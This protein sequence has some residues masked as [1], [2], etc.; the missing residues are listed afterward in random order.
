MGDK[1]TDLL[2]AVFTHAG[3]VRQVQVDERENNLCIIRV[4]WTPWS[5]G[6]FEEVTQDLLKAGTIVDESY[7]YFRAPNNARTV[8]ATLT[9]DFS[10]VDW[11]KN[12]AKQTAYI[13]AQELREAVYKDA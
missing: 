2:S 6:V 13:I 7:R 11:R 1:W 12:L 4:D 3:V 8:R 5:E 9:I 10:D